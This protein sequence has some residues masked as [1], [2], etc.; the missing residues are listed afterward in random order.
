MISLKNYFKQTS[1]KVKKLAIKL[2][3]LIGLCAASAFIQNDPKLSFYFMLA[4]FALNELLE[5]FPPDVTSTEVKTAGTVS[6]VLAL[7][8]A[9]FFGCTVIKPK[10]NTTKTDSTYTTYK[11]VTVDVKGAK[12]GAGL[13]LD[14]LYKA[15]LIAKDQRMDDSLS[16]LKAENKYKTDSIAALKANKP[17]PPKPVFIKSPPD[18]RYV[19]DPQT[20]AQL[21]YWVDRY[22]KLQ[23]GCESK[24]QLVQTLVA[25]V[26]TLHKQVTTTTQVAKI[27]PAWAW[28]IMAVEAVLLLI[29]M[30]LL[31]LERRAK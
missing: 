11:Q 30:V 7:V 3:I 29:V 4:G 23:L 26:N 15:L 8:A 27:T 2:K 14:S 28:V 20:K 10:V 17:L 24:D 19:T 21:S 12:V 9:G 16:N 1:P 18:V 13:N 25:Q 22:G 5:L 6:L 31:Q